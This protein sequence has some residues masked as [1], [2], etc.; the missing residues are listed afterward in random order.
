MATFTYD[1]PASDFPQSWNE[2]A[3]VNGTP[4]EASDPRS[5]SPIYCLLATARRG[6]DGACGSGERY[7]GGGDTI[8]GVDLGFSLGDELTGGGFSG[9]GSASS[10][11]CPPG[12]CIQ[13]VVDDG[14]PYTPEPTQNGWQYQNDWN[15]ELLSPGVGSEI[16]LPALNGSSE[17]ASGATAQSASGPPHLPSPD[18]AGLT[19]LV[20]GMAAIT[21]PF[22]VTAAN[23]AIFYTGAIQVEF[24]LG[25]AASSCFA[26]GVDLI[27]CGFGFP[28]GTA[29]AI[30]GG[31][32]IYGSY[33]F[34]RNITMP[35][36]GAWGQP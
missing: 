2:Y 20:G 26:P 12:G 5:L 16:G 21:R 18:T 31:A 7:G 6:T 1:E 4:L 25:L 30:Q 35:A 19:A 10:L 22:E 11:V 24:G 8:D 23:A 13:V 27:T 9:G 29:I 36:W 33:L 14:H 32:T 3:Y 34:F 15:G 17:P 28:A